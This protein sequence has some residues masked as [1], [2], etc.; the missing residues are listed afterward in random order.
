MR[1][2]MPRTPTIFLN[3]EQWEKLEKK[4]E[5]EGFPSIYAYM[6]D[7]MLYELNKDDREDFLEYLC[8]KLGLEKGE[9]MRQ[10]WKEFLEN[11]GIIPKG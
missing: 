7:L 4:F 9:L 1:D 2:I 11:H 3:N 6:K 8:D 5:A 10:A